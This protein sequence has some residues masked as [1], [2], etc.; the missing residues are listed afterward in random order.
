M[1][2]A[3]ALML[4]GTAVQAIG[5]I[6]QGNAQAAAYKQDAANADTNAQI[7]TA[8]GAERANR[9][10]QRARRIL[11]EQRAALGESGVVAETGSNLSLVQDSATQA[12]LDALSERYAAR[13]ETLGFQSQ[14]DQYRQQASQARV[15]GYTSAVG[16]LLGG[17]ASYGSFAT[18]PTK[19]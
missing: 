18:R 11:A 14:A 3:P 6:Q 4:A 19:K 12:E 10:R 5:A 17:A 9:V 2:L 1:Q 16:A 8:Q 13:L 15:G 7:A